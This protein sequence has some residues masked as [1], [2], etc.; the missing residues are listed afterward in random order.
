MKRKNYRVD[1]EPNWT[2]Q[3]KWVWLKV[4]EGDIADFNQREERN[5][6]LDPKDPEGW[7]KD[8]V[9]RASFLET[10]IKDEYYQHSV[11][12]QGVRITGAW[13]NE[14]IDLR[15]TS[16]LHPFWLP[17]C[18]FD[19]LVTLRGLRISQSLHLFGSAF[20]DILVLS[21]VSVLGDLHLFDATFKTLDLSDAKVEGIL[22]LSR[23]HVTESLKM[24]S[25]EVGGYLDLDENCSNALSLMGTKVA[26]RVSLNNARVNTDLDMRDVRFESDLMMSEATLAGLNLGRATIRG[27]V[28]GENIKITGPANLFQI[29]IDGSFTWKSAKAT[30]ISL[31]AGTINR[32]LSLTGSQCTG[33]IHTNNLRVAG[34][35][36]L[37][38]GKFAT[39]ELLDSK[40]TG[41]VSISQ[42]QITEK[43]DLTNTDVRGD[44]YAMDSMISN[45]RLTLMKVGGAAILNRSLLSGELDMTAIKISRTLQL[46]GVR[47]GTRLGMVL[48][49]AEVF[50]NLYISGEKLPS[51]NL[52]CAKIHGNLELGTGKYPV[53]WDL[54][55]T[56]DLL[57]AE[58][59][60]F[61]DGA[62]SATTSLG[63][64]DDLGVATRD[65][66][67]KKLNLAGFTYSRLPDFIA[68]RNMKWH[69]EWLEK[70]EYSPQPYR[71]LANILEK[72]GYKEKANEI[73][74]TQ[75]NREWS[76]AG[77]R[78][79]I[80]LSLLWVFIGYGFRVHRA[81]YWV[82]GLAGIG[83]TILILSNHEITGSLVDSLFYTLD[84][85]LPVIVLDKA[86]E[87]IALTGVVKVYF[88]FLKVMGY[89]LASFLIAGLGGLTKK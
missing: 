12:Q 57:D 39:V 89:I 23:S 4:C 22:E 61:L 38:E 10:I 3:E 26:G 20:S 2:D 37:T 52:T 43:L 11:P 54:N 53:S 73:L 88:Y 31:I 82:L 15:N 56:L 21:D 40:I 77:L 65:F 9:L 5:G 41:H 8:R 71:Q 84:T 29:Q 81:L 14:P 51:L 28:F 70:S 46:Q 49:F 33:K 16:I 35:L 78:R 86:H 42:S 18:L 45:M 58:V 30:E 48:G 80:W 74:Y 75:K 24:Q 34:D 85:V 7:N 87:K 62:Q 32:D 1:P 69:R 6:R 83:L 17:F 60:S 68:K 55:A 76:L 19:K 13:F 25:L 64:P 27:W 72:M 47:S 79:K 59:V 50:G 44:L 63:S 66:W 36:H 67:P